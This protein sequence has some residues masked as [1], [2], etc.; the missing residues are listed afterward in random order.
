MDIF[1]ILSRRGCFLSPLL[2]MLGFIVVDISLDRPR[3]LEGQ[4]VTFNA[5]CQTGMN[6]NNATNPQNN[7]KVTQSEIQH[8][9]RPEEQAAPFQNFDT[10]SLFSRNFTSSQ[11]ERHSITHTAKELSVMTMNCLKNL[12]ICFATISVLQNANELMKTMQRTKEAQPVM[13]HFA[14]IML[15]SMCTQMQW[16]HL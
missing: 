6:N 14:I 15:R 12:D 8:K 4:H 11:K 10:I 13:S 9:T 5:K 2:T 3:M 1:K 7:L 16:K